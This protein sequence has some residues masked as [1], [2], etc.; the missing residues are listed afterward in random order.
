MSQT[1]AITTGGSVRRLGKRTKKWLTSLKSKD[2]GPTIFISG[3]TAY[4]K[5]EDILKSEAAQKQIKG[6]KELFKQH[7]AKK[8][9]G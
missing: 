3:P 6:L 2:T 9:S 1:N 7:K 8:P 5:S 4:I